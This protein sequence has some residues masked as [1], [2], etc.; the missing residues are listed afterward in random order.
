MKKFILLA[1][2]LI[3]NIYSQ[4]SMSMVS[5][6]PNI[7]IQY[8]NVVSGFAT[9]KTWYVGRFGATAPYDSST[10]TAQNI[11]NQSFL[12]SAGTYK[13]IRVFIAGNAGI[14]TA[15]VTLVKIT[16]WTSSVPSAYSETALVVNG[17]ATTTGTLT[18]NTTSTVT[19]SD[20]D[21]YVLKVRF[22]SNGGFS[23]AS[24]I[25]T[26]DFVPN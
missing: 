8:Y 20:G 1:F 22:G 16:A 5:T 14:T 6:K 11:A 9:S 2:L 3:G 26:F 4:G 10:A 23:P 25:V 24:F 15:V 17:S 19:A 18:S 12:S 13:N 7:P 21:I